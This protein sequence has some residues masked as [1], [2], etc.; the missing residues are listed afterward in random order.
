MQHLLEAGEL[1]EVMPTARA[2]GMPV[3][4]LYPHRRQ[5]SRRV[6]VFLDWFEGLMQAYVDA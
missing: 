3:S 6:A 5:R 1:I 2:A 4:L